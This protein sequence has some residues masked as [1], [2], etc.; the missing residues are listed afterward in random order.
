[1]ATADQRAELKAA[2]GADAAR[3]YAELMLN[4]HLGGM[5]MAQ[6]A[7]DH[8]SESAV[9]VLAQSMIKSQ[10]SDISEL[11]AIIARLG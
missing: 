9:R 7:A 1:M 5:H 10:Q 2:T 3:L 4:H 8:A 6:Y 11:R